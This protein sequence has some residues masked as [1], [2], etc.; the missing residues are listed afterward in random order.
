MEILYINSLPG[1]GAPEH[2]YVY[3][4]LRYAGSGPCTYVYVYTGMRYTGS[5]H[6]WHVGWTPL[7]PGLS[8]GSK[9][10]WLSP[11]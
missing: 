2:V 4:V 6:T 11:R 7:N 1:R 9:T 5:G 8:P 3:A 10:I